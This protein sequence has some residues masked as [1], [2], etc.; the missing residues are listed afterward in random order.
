MVIMV[1]AV[2]VAMAQAPEKFT[3]QAVVRNASNALVAN[4][5]VGVRVSILQG[6]ASGSAVYME[7]QAATTNANGLVTLSIGGGNVQQ[8]TFGNIDWSA[9]PYFLKTEIDPAGGNNYSVTS[10]QQLLSVPYALYSKE[11]GN[12]FSGDYNDLTNTPDIPTVPTNVSAFT[13]DAGYLTIYTETDPQF[14]AWDKDYNDLT[15]K[16]VLFDGDYNS[17][18]NKPVLFDGDYNSLTN[19]PTIPTVPTNVSAFTNDVGYLTEYTEQQVLSISNDTLF[20]TG[21]SFVKLPAGF[22]GDYNSLTNKP[23]I[24]TVPTNV[25]AFNNDAGYITSEDIPEIPTVPTNVSAFTNDAGYLTSYTE[26]QT[27]ADVTSQGNSAGNRQLKD[28][29]DP[30]ES[31]DAVNLR[32]LASHIN[33]LQDTF[34][35][36]MQQMQQQMS[37]MQQKIDSLQNIV[38]SLD[39]NDNTP[40][41]TVVIDEKSCPA[42]PTVTDH[43]GNVYATVQIGNQCWMRD[44]LR[45]TTSPSTG[46]Y[47]IPAAGTGYTLTGKQAFWYDN[48]SATYAPM[49][50]GLLYNWNAAVDTFNTAY[51][52]TS[53]NTSSSDAVSAT[54]TGHRRGICPAGW[55]LPSDAEWTQLETY[56]GSQSEYVCGSDSSYIAK[57]LASETGWISVQDNYCAVGN[58]QSANNATDFS[59]VPAGNCLGSSFINTGIGVDFWS[60]SQYEN[61]PTIASFRGLY[62]TNAPVTRNNYTKNTGCSVRC[63]RDETS[64]GGGT[65]ATL[66]TVTTGSVSDVTATSVTCGGNVTS[67]GGASVTARGVCWSTSQ[68]PTVSD[69]HT[70]D[71]SGTGSFTSN[72]TG[73]A[74]NTTYYVRAYAT[75]SAGTAYG[76][77]VNFATESISV[78]E[79]VVDEKSCPGTPTVTD[80]EGNVYATVQIGNQ[81]WMRDNL[82]TTTSPSTGTYLIPAAGTGETFTGKQARWYNNDSTTYAPMNYGLLYNW[83]AAVDTFNTSYGETSVSTDYNSAVSVT[84]TGHRRGIC[85]AGWHLPSDAEWTQLT[86][87]VSS[88]SEYTCDSNSNYIAKALASTEGWNTS[89][90]NCVVGNDPS[91]NN[92]TGFSVVPAGY[93]SGSSFGDAGLGAYFWSSTQDGSNYAYDSSPYYDDAH[94]V[95]NDGVKYDGRSVRCLRDSGGGDGSSATLPTVTT[96][97]ISN[98]TPT[99]AT[100]GGNIIADGGASV[101]ACGVCWSTSQNPT[102]NGSHTADGS[103][104]GSFSSSISG[105]TANTTYYVR[106][107]ATN[108]V[109]TAYGE[110]VTFTT[111]SAGGTAV[112]DSKSCPGTPTVTDHEGNVYATVQIGNQC[113]MRDNLR[114]TTSPSTGTYLIPAAGTDYTY[115]G[116]QAFWY[117]NDSATYAPMNYGLLYNWNAAMDTFNTAYGETSVN[118]LSPVSVNGDRR[119]ICPVGWHLPSQEEWTQLETYVYSQSEYSCSYLGDVAKALASETGWYNSTDYYYCSVGNDP[120]SNNATGFSAVPAGGG[121]NSSFNDAGTDAWF[122]SSSQRDPY[123]TVAIARRLSYNS[124]SLLKQY[125][126]KYNG[127]SVRCL[128]DESGNA[129]TTVIPTDT[130]ATPDDTTTVTAGVPCPGTP[131]V[132]DHEG[133]VYA[134]VLIGNQCWMRDNLRTTTSPST[135][136]YLIPAAGTGETFTGK[137]ARWYNN[138]S[139]TYAPMNYGLLY[140]WNAAVD[141]FNTSYGETS[142]NTDY[143]NAESVTFSGHRRGICPVGWHLPSDAEWTQLETYV[144]SRSEYVCGSDSS[145]IAKALASTEGWGTNTNNC[146][147]GNDPSTNNATGFSAVPAGICVGSSFDYAGYDAGFRSSTQDHSYSYGAYSRGL[148]YG[149]ADVYGGNGDK[150]HGYSVRCLRD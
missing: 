54:F 129:D 103:G 69:N 76:D 12:S 39:T 74:A 48:D 98:I 89:T 150:G 60:S 36:Q 135:G 81:C 122:W 19:Q 15:N 41:G 82:R 95:R 64:G 104:M 51:G 125:T 47:L 52:E 77:E 147:V 23:T 105:L 5:L 133:N 92:A 16:P 24:P 149:F 44:N 142:V 45:T 100:C 62:Y 85:P 134:T 26:S 40:S 96:N 145:Y 144:G 138:D 14:N 27:L 73:L 136:T 66:P 121:T 123:L 127:Y 88:Q 72:I 7:T 71:G 108:S 109:G 28:V 93:C 22:D 115:T 4:T 17:L 6:G 107:Y 37:Q 139:A 80:H 90:N 53:V 70:T 86:N 13:N 75:N 117:D 79:P 140:N 65:A 137:Q 124:K 33:S 10:T 112:I 130:T 8:G 143:Y 94:V 3:Y 84:F 35:Q 110:E 106:A 126:A 116:K 68:N 58:D 38:N 78:P 113:W 20:L 102:V 59:A 87:Y 67:D 119:G 9:G 49:N 18:S 63:L 128:R 29:S 1:L 99:T 11:A 31:Y 97:T 148:N 50:Y 56:V 132:T 146:T 21:G 114:T 34:Q 111:L 57:A 46:T 2:A 43:E 25:S 30:T 141:T 131:T 120:S 32:T 61:I 55:H 91:T 101:T 42:A 118:N 83:N